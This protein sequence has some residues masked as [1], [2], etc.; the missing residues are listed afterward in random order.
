[1]TVKP[2]IGVTVSNRGATM[3]WLAHW[4]AVKRAGGKPVRLSVNGKTDVDGLDGLGIGG[5]P[6]SGK[7]NRHC[8]R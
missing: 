6:L 5:G 8:Y 2:R 4:L 3:T 1:M 7:P